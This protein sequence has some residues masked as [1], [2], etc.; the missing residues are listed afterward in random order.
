MDWLR[1]FLFETA[2]S[3]LFTYGL[4]G[5]ISLFLS[6][7][8]FRWY[9]EIQREKSVLIFAITN[10]FQGAAFIGGALVAA[11]NPVTDFHFLLPVVLVAWIGTIIGIG[12]G[13]YLAYWKLVEISRQRREWR[14]G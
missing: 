7:V 11:R 10:I 13:T 1:W 8:R 9:F 2:W 6:Y 12:Y 4:F 14:G 3:A 5:L